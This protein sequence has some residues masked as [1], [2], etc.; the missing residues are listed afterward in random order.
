M[1][2]QALLVKEEI[3]LEK[4]LL[5][6]ESLEVRKSWNYVFIW[7]KCFQPSETEVSFR[8]R[9]NFISGQENHSSEIFSTGWNWTQFSHPRGFY[10]WTR[11]S[12]EWNFFNRVKLDSV[13]APER[14]LFLD[15]KIIR[16]KFF[17][18]GETG[19]SFHTREDFISG[20]ENHS[21]EKFSTGWNLDSRPARKFSIR[22]IFE[23]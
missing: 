23:K 7:V 18:P 1:L 10:F 12:F 22:K 3:I 19:L 8:T 21:N 15:K 4:N 6:F 17:Q 11:K 9:E 20:Q 13:F 14:I 5:K 16:V 2:I